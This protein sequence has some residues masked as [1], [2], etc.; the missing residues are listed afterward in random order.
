MLSSLSHLLTLL[1]LLPLAY[2]GTNAIIFYTSEGCSGCCAAVCSNLNPN[3]CCGSTTSLWSSVTLGAFSGGSGILYRVWAAAG[4]VSS[5]G[6]ACAV[7][8]GSNSGC[9]TAS[10]SIQGAK[11]SQSQILTARDDNGGCVEPDSFWVTVGQTR[12]TL[13]YTNT[14]VKN[15]VDENVHD[16]KTALFAFAERHHIAKD[17][18]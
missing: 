1:V 12:Y 4:Q 7:I 18:L 3:T 8:I 13:D 14:T 2:C 10:D 5:P 17:D 9:V 6:Y 15:F 11:F 16:N